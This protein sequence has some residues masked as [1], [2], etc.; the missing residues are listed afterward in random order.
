MRLLII[1]IDKS[2]NDVTRV[3]LVHKLFIPRV[4]TRNRHTFVLSGMVLSD[5]AQCLTQR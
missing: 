4:K 1:Y 5:I 2:G 3:E